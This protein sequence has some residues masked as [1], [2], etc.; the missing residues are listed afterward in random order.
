MDG[1]IAQPNMFQGKKKYIYIYMELKNIISL[2]PS[3][4]IVHVQKLRHK[5]IPT[6]K[7]KTH[8]EES[9]EKIILLAFPRTAL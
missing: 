6:N 1:G 4:F 2:V 7:N 5:H 9:P 3:V 8:S